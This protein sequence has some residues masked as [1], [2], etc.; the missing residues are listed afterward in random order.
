[1][2][3]RLENHSTFDVCFATGSLRRP[4]EHKLKSVGIPFE[5]WQLV[6]SDHIKERE[7][8]VK[9]AIKHAEEHCNISKFEQIIA[10]GDGLWDLVTAR[11]LGVDFIGVGDV[12]EDILIRN[13]ATIVCKDLTEFPIG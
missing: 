7:E 11:N 3:N 4:A 12:N 13:G 10:V 5:N 9:R 6:A 8:I 1:M 2:I